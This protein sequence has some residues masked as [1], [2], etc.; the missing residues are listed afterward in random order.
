MGDIFYLVIVILIVRVLWN[1]YSPNVKGWIGEKAV[2]D[3]LEKLPTDQY[4]IIKVG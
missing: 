1:S 2:A 3:I 4:K